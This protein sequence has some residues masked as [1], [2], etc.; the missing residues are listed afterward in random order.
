MIVAVKIYNPDKEEFM[1]K[2]GG[3]NKKGKSWSSLKDAKLAI[4]PNY[5]YSYTEVNSEFWLFSDDGKLEKIPVYHYFIDYFERQIKES[6]YDSYKE[7]N[8]KRLKELTDY[9]KVKGKVI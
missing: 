9:L 5:G 7:K 8:T 1:C 6:R 3:W 4:C 2:G